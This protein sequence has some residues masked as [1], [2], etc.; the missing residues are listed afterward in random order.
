[1]VQ[2]DTRHW[3]TSRTINFYVSP[4]RFFVTTGESI[5]GRAWSN[6]SFDPLS[7]LF[8]FYTSLKQYL[9]PLSEFFLL[10]F[11]A[12][13]ICLPQGHSPKLCL[14]PAVSPSSHWTRVF[15]WERKYYLDPKSWQ[16]STLTKWYNLILSV[17][18]CSN[19]HLYVPVYKQT[20]L[21]SAKEFPL[22]KFDWPK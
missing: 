10:Q 20:R 13:S 18:I 7:E 15:V 6:I 22:R 2:I 11:P 8:P 5:A 12:L 14:R 21:L 19:L 17:R 4:Q 3:V 1:M 16:S 9:L